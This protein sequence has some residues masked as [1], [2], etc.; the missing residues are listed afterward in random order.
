M[1]FVAKW[2]KCRSM[3]I[4]L[5]FLFWCKITNKRLFSIK[6]KCSTIKLFIYAPLLFGEWSRNV[7]AFELCFVIVNSAKIHFSLL[8]VA[9]HCSFCFLWYRLSIGASMLSEF[10]K[11]SAVSEANTIHQGLD[12]CCWI[13]LIVGMTPKSKR[14]GSVYQMLLNCTVVFKKRRKIVV[15]QLWISY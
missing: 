8:T 14:I 2:K 1:R 9:K 7:Y 11:V 12:S 15:Y 13:S 5:S 10:Y 3:L 6:K 4:Q